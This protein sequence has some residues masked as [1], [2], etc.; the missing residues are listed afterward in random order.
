MC[1]KMLGTFLLTWCLCLMKDHQNL[2]TIKTQWFPVSLHMEASFLCLGLSSPFPYFLPIFHLFPQGL[3]RTLLRVQNTTATAGSVHPQLMFAFLATVVF[4]PACLI[5]FI[6][7]GQLLRI[8]LLNCLRFVQP[9]PPH[10]MVQCHCPRYMVLDWQRVC[11]TKWED[12]I[13]FFLGN[14]EMELKTS[15]GWIHHLG[16]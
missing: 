12:E 3:P 1:S 9:W 8:L 7:G 2:P 13:F 6:C 14:S 15:V 10:C 4:L 16:T 11:S 5:P